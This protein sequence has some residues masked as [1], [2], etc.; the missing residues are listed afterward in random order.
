MGPREWWKNGI[1]GMKSGGGSNF[2]YGSMP[3]LKI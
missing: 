1:V 2:I 3:L